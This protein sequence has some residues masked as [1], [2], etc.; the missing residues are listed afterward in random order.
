MNQELRRLR[1]ANLADT[2]TIPAP[3][4]EVTLRARTSK[5]V[6]KQLHRL[7]RRG[8]VHSASDLGR[9][10]ARAGGGYG[11]KVR[12][13]KPLP[14]PMPGWAKGLSLVGC[15]FIGLAVASAFLVK[16]LSDLIPA[17]TAL[18]WEAILGGVLVLVVALMIVKRVVF[19]SDIHVQQNVWIKR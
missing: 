1:P 6:L 8:F 4:G 3:V 5:E 18:P 7:E 14:E 11:V 19:G 12:L 9:F 15:V 13:T 10:H 17:A 16:A 2:L